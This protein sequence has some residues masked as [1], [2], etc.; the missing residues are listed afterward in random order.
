M[1]ALNNTK[2]YPPKGAKY[3]VERKDSKVIIHCKNRKQAKIA[4]EVLTVDFLKH[5][6]IET[7]FLRRMVKGDIT[8]VH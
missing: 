1:E 2:K 7:A 8:G 6:D 5:L 3:T 4:F